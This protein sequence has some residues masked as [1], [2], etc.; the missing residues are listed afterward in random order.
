MELDVQKIGKRIPKTIAFVSRKVAAIGAKAAGKAAAKVAGKTAGKAGK[1]VLGKI[2][3]PFPK[4]ASALK[5][6]AAFSAVMHQE[7]IGT[8]RHMQAKD[9]SLQKELQ[10]AYGYAVFPTVG[11]ATAVLGGAYGLG[12]VFEHGRVVGYAAIVQVMI[13]LQLGGQTYHELVLFDSREA[14]QSFKQSKVAFA[15]TASAVAIS[16]GAAAS[17]ASNGM[18]VFVHSEGGMMVEAAIGGQKFIFKPAVLGRLKSIDSP[19][20]PAG[21]A[22]K[23]GAP[24]APPA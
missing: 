7:V 18:R 8:L 23:L 3:S 1:G 2:T 15:A 21:E 17:K 5:K 13:G 11:K 4:L 12:E 9:P 16:V 20:A 24:P 22:S 14:L 19:K 10:K 6:E